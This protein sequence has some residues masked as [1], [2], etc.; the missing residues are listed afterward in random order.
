MSARARCRVSSSPSAMDAFR[1]LP[2]RQPRCSHTG[3]SATGR[4]PVTPAPHPAGLR[5]LVK[6]SERP[7]GHD[8]RLQSRSSR[9][10]RHRG[11]RGVGE[12]F[13][14]FR[15]ETPR[16]HRRR[17]RGPGPVARHAARSPQATVQLH[18]FSAYTQQ[19]GFASSS[20]RDGGSPSKTDPHAGP[21]RLTR[22]RARQIP[23]RSR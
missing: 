20:S 8:G 3:A 15:D 19:C 11:G 22:R 1:P 2:C 6:P 14:T 5:R 13:L 23:S 16:R 4:A 21:G 10:S 18:P 7:R 9:T 12:A 17:T